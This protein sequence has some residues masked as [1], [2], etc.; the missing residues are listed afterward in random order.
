MKNT[1]GEKRHI[2]LTLI[3]KK[4][5]ELNRLKK[6]CHSPHWIFQKNI[7]DMRISQMCWA[8][9]FNVRKTNMFQW[10]K[11]IVVYFL[12]RLPLSCGLNEPWQEAVIPGVLSYHG[13]K[14]EKDLQCLILGIKNLALNWLCPSTFNNLSRTDDG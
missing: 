4:N 6:E 7:N 2:M 11:I 3:K 9:C 13:R 14:Q 12:L 8:V 5:V 1:K 10:L